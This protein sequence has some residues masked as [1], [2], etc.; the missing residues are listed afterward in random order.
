MINYEM[1][2]KNCR[3]LENIMKPIILNHKKIRVNQR[4]N[5]LRR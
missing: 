1:I 3:L 5:K 4:Q 2:L